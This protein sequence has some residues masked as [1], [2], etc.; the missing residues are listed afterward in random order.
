MIKAL[1]SDFSV[2]STTMHQ[3]I[4]GEPRINVNIHKFIHCLQPH[5][6]VLRL[7]TYQRNIPTSKLLMSYF[8]CEGYNRLERNEIK[9]TPNTVLW[10]IASME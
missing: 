6:Y 3:S 4:N 2:V 9:T 8:L 1:H 10:H 7:Q 5:E